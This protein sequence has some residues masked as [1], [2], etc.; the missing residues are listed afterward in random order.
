M[1]ARPANPLAP[2]LALTGVWLMIVTI[3]PPVADFPLNDDWIYAKV[4]QHLVDTGQYRSNPYS[5]PTFILQA[6]WG[7]AFVKLFGFSFDTLRLSTLLLG[8]IAAWATCWCAAEAALSRRWSFLC[9]LVLLVNPLF[10][11]ASYTFMTDVPFIAALA[12]ST[13]GFLRALRTDRVRWVWYAN[14][15]AVAAFFI[16]QFGVLVPVAFAP[17][18]LM[19]PWPLVRKKAPH[20]VAALAV[21][22]MV[23]A[24]LLQVLPVG[25][26]DLAKP[27]DWSPLGSTFSAR[28]LTVATFLATALVYLALFAAPLLVTIRD[29][30]GKRFPRRFERSHLLLA[31]VTGVLGWLVFR[32]KWDRPPHFGNVLYDFGVG[33]LLMPWAV[34]DGKPDPVLRLEDGVWTAIVVPLIPGAACLA[35]WLARALYGGLTRH[36][37]EGATDRRVDFSLALLT[38]ALV[39]PLILPPVLARFDRYF[40]PALIPLGILAARSVTRRFSFEP[41]RLDFAL[42][43]VSLALAVLSLQDYLAWNRARWQAL[44]TLRT[45]FSAPLEQID[46]GYEFNGWFHSE[47][48]VEASHA[49]GKKVFGPKGWWIV[50]DEY[51]IMGGGVPGD[52][53]MSPGAIVRMPLGERKRYEVIGTEPYFTWL[54]MQRREIALLKRYDAEE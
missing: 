9:G 29:A 1:T 28:F 8:L 48:F 11:N 12:I 52:R 34:A 26:E 33:P 41:T 54:G 6:Y 37:S 17:A 39:C 46:G 50:G 19:L 7:A 10:V 47:R 18:L 51:S 15:A 16:R 3:V 25:G 22:W 14:L 23:A 44:N 42:P 2:Y 27:W 13:A 53:A 49:E 21:P 31:A 45:E 5:D 4:V 38:L 24:V 36:G 32:S 40:L 43:A 35:L 30:S 20:L